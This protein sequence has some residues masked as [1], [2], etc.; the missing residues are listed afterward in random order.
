MNLQHNHKRI[1]LQMLKMGG[2]TQEYEI[3]TPGRNLEEIKT[4][5]DVVDVSMLPKA[6]G[7]NRVTIDEEGIED[8]S[9]W[10][11]FN[12]LSLSEYIRNISEI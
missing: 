5:T 8:E 12:H 6:I 4:I 1:I 9:C 7:G 3:I 10:R 11:G 2:L